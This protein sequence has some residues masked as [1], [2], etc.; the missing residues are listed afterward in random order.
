ML[1]KFLSN[2]KKPKGKFGKMIVSAMNRA[3]TSRSLGVRGVSAERRRERSTSLRRRGLV[4]FWS[5]TQCRAD[6]IDY[7]GKRCMQ[8]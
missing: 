8:P 6:G 3:C 2:C 5:A 1:K 4:A 7:S